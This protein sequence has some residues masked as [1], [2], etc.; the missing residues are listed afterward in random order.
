MCSMKNK[1]CLLR[2][3]TY[4]YLEYDD[5]ESYHFQICMNHTTP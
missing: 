3:L 5:N 4:M 1:S 2:P